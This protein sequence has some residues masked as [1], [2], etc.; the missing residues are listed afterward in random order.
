MPELRAAPD[1]LSGR[2]QGQSRK[3]PDVKILGDN[4]SVYKDVMHAV[5]REG[6]KLM[7]TYNCCN[8]VRRTREKYV[9]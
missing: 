6:R 7:T 3:G 2:V 1:S 8:G 4:F 5:V 9:A